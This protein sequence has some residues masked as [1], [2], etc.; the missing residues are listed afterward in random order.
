MP[1]PRLPS[2]VDVDQI[3]ALADPVVRNYQITQCYHELALGLSERTG[4]RPNW[5]TF[6]T[7]A[8]NQA[9]V[10]IRQEDLAQALRAVL[11]P[12]APG[13]EAARGVLAAAQA[14]GAPPELAAVEQLV[15]QGWSPQEAFDRASDAVARGNRKVFDEIGRAFARFYADCLPDTAYDAARIAQFG[16]TLRPGDP[17]E[18]QQYLRQAFARYYQALFEPAPQAQAELLLLANIEIGYHEQ[19]RLQPEILEALD[20]PIP[21]AAAL[22]RRLVTALFRQGSWLVVA[23]WVW[24]WLLRRPTPL[25]LAVDRLVAALQRRARLITTDFLMTI[26]LPGGRTLRLG[27]DLRAQYPPTLQRLTNTELQ[28]LLAR[29]DP[30]PDSPAGTGARDWADLP[31][32]LHFILDMFRCFGDAPDL[33]SPPFTPEQVAAVKAGRRA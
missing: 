15:A 9:G 23:G 1:A 17:P 14:M 26:G 3:A 21:D 10:T 6:A 2:L 32:R 22:K 20:A 28:A 31:Q 25:D 29:I 8:S 12:G 11:A 16:E 24:S 30:T 5:C 33:F 19:T 27:D 7:W 13:A 4:R 18:G